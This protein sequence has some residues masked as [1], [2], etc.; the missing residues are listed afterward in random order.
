[1]FDTAV[2][3]PY[4]ILQHSTPTQPRRLS[5]QTC[6]FSHRGGKDLT[7][8]NLVGYDIDR[9]YRNSLL[10]Q[11]DCRTQA[12]GASSFLLKIEAT[13]MIFGS[14]ATNHKSG[15]LDGFGYTAASEEVLQQIA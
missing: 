6:Y 11:F 2:N 1:M 13:K 12:N 14:E 10:T 9:S 15:R 4:S 3:H 8:I 7:C 5:E